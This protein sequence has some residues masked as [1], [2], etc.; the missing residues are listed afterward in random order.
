MVAGLLPSRDA[1]M[2]EDPDSPYA[3]LIVIRA[4]MENDPRVQQLVEALHSKPV[5]DKAKE[6]FKDQAIP[7]WK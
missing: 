3:N 7:A 6:L 4:G 2:I 1:L 5:L